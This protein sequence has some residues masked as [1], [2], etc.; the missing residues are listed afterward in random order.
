MTIHQNIYKIVCPKVLSYFGFSRAVFC[1]PPLE[2][3][4]RTLVPLSRQRLP[5]TRPL[6]DTLSALQGLARNVAADALVLGM[7]TATCVLLFSE[8]S[9][10]SPSPDY[11]PCERVNLPPPLRGAPTANWV[12]TVM[13]VPI[14]L[15]PERI[16]VNFCVRPGFFLTRMR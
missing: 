11:P 8:D 15:Y 3:V 9:D 5:E 12:R 13:D 14:T 1:W 4:L 2:P 6:R 10:K 7:V 16:R